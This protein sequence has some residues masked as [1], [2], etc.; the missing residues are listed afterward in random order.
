MGSIVLVVVP[1]EGRYL[2]VEELDGTWYLPAGKVEPGENL[3]AAAVRE[4]AEEAGIAIGLRG[5]LAIE[6]DPRRFRFVFVGYPALN[7]PP[8]SRPD[9]HT[10]GAAWKTRAELA[11]MPL[12]HPEV[13]AWIERYEAATALLPCAAYHP[14][15]LDAP[16]MWSATLG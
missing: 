10:R 5:L 4:T 3:I 8:K 15:A 14:Y 11:K 6:H 16:S 2:V 9:R 12:R 7:V 1:N 13:L